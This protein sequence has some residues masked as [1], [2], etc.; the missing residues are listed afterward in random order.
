MPE[1]VDSGILTNFTTDDRTFSMGQLSMS[2]FQIKR[3]S[4]NDSLPF[5]LDSSVAPQVAGMDLAT[6]Q[7]SGRLFYTDWRT[8]L[9]NLEL[10]LPLY[11]A[12]CDAYFYISPNSS[13]FLP[14][15]VRARPSGSSV[16]TVYSPADSHY[17]WLFAKMMF[18]TANLYGTQLAHLVT[19]HDKAE[20]ILEAAMR[21]LSIDHPVYAMMRRRKSRA[22]SVL[23]A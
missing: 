6:L 15:A 16:D 19:T 13:D 18:N 17:D 14:L 21:T 2:P 9:L 8:L 7:S 3:L 1:R 4:P 12:A 20:I 10:N 11:G 5:D 23:C 22:T